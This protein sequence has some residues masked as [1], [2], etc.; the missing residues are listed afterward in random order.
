MKKTLA[1]FL[2]IVL[3]GTV[4]AGG[5]KDSAGKRSNSGKAAIEDFQM[6]K[7]KEGIN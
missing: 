1:G 2:L 5:G 3:C 6:K 7:N 4:F